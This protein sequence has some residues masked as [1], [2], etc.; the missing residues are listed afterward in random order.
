[1][2]MVWPLAATL[3]TY[4]SKP[5]KNFAICNDGS[6]CVGK[7]ESAVLQGTVPEGP[8]GEEL[9]A[10]PAVAAVM[11][12]VEGAEAET[13][14]ESSELPHKQPH[15]QVDST[16]DEVDMDILGWGEI[17]MSVDPVQFDI[18]SGD[19]E[20]G[21]ELNSER[22]AAMEP[23]NISGPHSAGSATTMES[24][25]S[26]RLPKPH[27]AHE[28]APILSEAEESLINEAIMGI[29]EGD[30]DMDRLLADIAMEEEFTSEV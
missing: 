3:L 21:I 19:M 4:V 30:V 23:D 17:D 11:D 8:C 7:V 24:D 15:K 9:K 5:S 29:A 27:T 18:G 1:M 26:S 12:S 6:S 10:K 13:V 2:A 20:L 14:A 16:A 25:P 28:Y 22:P